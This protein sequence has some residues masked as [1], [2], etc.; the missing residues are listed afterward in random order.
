MIQGKM[1]DHVG[2]RL[3][4]QVLRDTDVEGSSI[5]EV[6]RAAHDDLDIGVAETQRRA[7]KRR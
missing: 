4:D 3:D 1:K 7:N 6:Q 2:S 5:R